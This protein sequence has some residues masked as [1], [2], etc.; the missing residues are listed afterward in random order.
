M[1]YLVKLLNYKIE[2][3]HELVRFGKLPELYCFD[4]GLVES[5]GQVMRSIDF[6][7]WVAQGNDVGDHRLVDRILGLQERMEFPL[8]HVGGE[9]RFVSS[10]RRDN[11]Y[12]LEK[13]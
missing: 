13:G 3:F 2:L 10:A 6:H 4:K 8:A 9:V 7:H 11:R 12:P 5:L 1:Y